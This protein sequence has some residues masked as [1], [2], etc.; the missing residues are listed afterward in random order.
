MKSIF[1]LMAFIILSGCSSTDKDD[2]KLEERE[3]ENLQR[4]Y[5][6]KDASSKFRPGWI[7]DAEVWAK[8]YSYDLKKYR[9]FS[10]ESEPKISRTMA[11]NLAKANTKADIAGEITTFIDKTLSESTEG[12]AGIDPNNPT[13]NSLRQYVSNNLTSKIQSLIYGAAVVKTYWEKRS[14]STDLGAKKDYI[15]YTCGVLVRMPASRL[16]R[17]IDQAVEIVSN[18]VKDK[19]MKEKVEKALKNANENFQKARQGE[20]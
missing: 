15:G 18:R 16:N 9:F 6:V 2:R 20:I 12:E 1:L 10:F 3:H 17:A 11:C 4:D 14:F 7:E 5:I 13:I 8:N 19:E